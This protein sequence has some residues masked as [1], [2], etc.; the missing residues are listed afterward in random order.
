MKFSESSSQPTDAI[1]NGRTSHDDKPS[2]SLSEYTISELPDIALFVR[3]IVLL[4]RKWWR[5]KRI[6][7]SSTQLRHSS[8]YT[9][10]Y[11]H[12]CSSVFDLPV[13]GVNEKRSMLLASM[14]KMANIWLK[15]VC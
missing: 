3:A 1:L 8:E 6:L 7:V 11:A 2:V 4:L 12:V 10:G 13:V 9:T 14:A 5:V 15:L